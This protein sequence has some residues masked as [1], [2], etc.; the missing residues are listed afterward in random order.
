MMHVRSPQ[1]LLQISLAVSLGLPG[2]QIMPRSECPSAPKQCKFPLSPQRQVRDSP[3]A[4][5]L[6]GKGGAVVVSIMAVTSAASAELIAGS[7]IMQVW[8]VHVLS[9][10]RTHSLNA[11]S[12]KDLNVTTLAVV[13]TQLNVAYII[14]IDIHR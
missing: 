4:A 9:C 3:A 7:S 6:M 10:L 2:F 1:Y 5:V 13:V 12:T 8:L 11:R 14:P